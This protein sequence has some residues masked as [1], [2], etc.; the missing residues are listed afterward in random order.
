M[1]K[2]LVKLTENELRNV[3]KEAVTGFLSDDNYSID[4]IADWEY[5]HSPEG[6]RNEFYPEGKKGD[7]EFDWDRNSGRLTKKQR[8]FRKDAMERMADKRK[9]S[10]YFTPK[11]E[12]IGKKIMDKWVKGDRSLDDIEDVDINFSELEERVSESVKRMV[13]EMRHD[14]YS[15]ESIRTIENGG[16]REVLVTLNNGTEIHI[17]PC[18]ESWEQFGGTIDELYTTVDVAEAYNNWLHGGDE[19]DENEVDS[20]IVSTQE[21]VFPKESKNRKKNVVKLTE[22]QLKEVVSESVRALIG[23]GVYGYPDGIDT[24]VLLSENDR[25]LYKVWESIAMTV[26]KLAA[27]GTEP[28]VEKLANSS[29]MK[30]YQQACFRKYAKEQETGFD[31][32]VSPSVFR[33]YMAE[34]MID[35]VNFGEWNR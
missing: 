12:R 33:K 31:P 30:A 29:T 32:R 11:E 26:A 21:P 9:R 22:S 15:I 4:G 14:R 13:S 3:I 16:E 18:H 10:K 17:V 23:E 1:A 20:L 24:I 6:I 19:P 27:K 2:K 25:E 34:R 5:E 7:T 35:E 8:D 28:S